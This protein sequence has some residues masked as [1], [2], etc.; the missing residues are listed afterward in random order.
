MKRKIKEIVFGETTGDIAVQHSLGETLDELVINRI[1]SENI[2]TEEVDIVL[3]ID[4]KEYDHEEFFKHLSDNYFKY[5][6]MQAEKLI[7]EETMDRIS[8]LKY[9]LDL[10]NSKVEALRDNIDF[11]MRIIKRTENEED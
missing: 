6:K 11:D 5:L 2:Q 7:V 1:S 4:G 9:S 3:T 10:L 8:D